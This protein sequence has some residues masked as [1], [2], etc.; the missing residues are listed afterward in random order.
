MSSVLVL[1]GF[2]SPRCLQKVPSRGSGEQ[3][4]GQSSARAERQLLEVVAAVMDGQ[5]GSLRSGLGRASPPREEGQ[6]GVFL[7]AW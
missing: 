1:E 5:T 4:Q 6:T 7:R 3:G 2:P